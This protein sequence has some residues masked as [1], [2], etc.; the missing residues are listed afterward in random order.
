MP[1]AFWP[2][3]GHGDRSL[4]QEAK[5]RHPKDPRVNLVA[6]Y[7][8]E[9]YDNRQPASPGRRELLES[10]KQSDP[11]NALGHYLAARDYFRANQTDK[12][13]EELTAASGK[14]RFEDYSTYFV[15][16]SE[17]AWRAAGFSE[18]EAKAIASACLRIA[19]LVDVKGL[20]ENLASLANA[21][22]Q[23][24]MPLPPKPCC[25]SE[26]PW[27]TSSTSLPLPG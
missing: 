15:Q 14:M 9:P 19:P 8:T 18:V 3:S 22:Q 23:A 21:Y 11:E 16:D 20:G 26:S 10:F 24:V 12:A 25:G 5:E 1:V 17:E 6:Y 7:S 2:P 4:L 27:E 13:V